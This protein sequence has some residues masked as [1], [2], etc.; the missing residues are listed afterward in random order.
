MIATAI[1]VTGENEKRAAVRQAGS[2]NGKFFERSIV[3]AEASEEIIGPR[4]MGF[5]RIGTEPQRIVH[6]IFGQRDPLWSWI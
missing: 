3:I 1:D 5:C 4:E 2:R 6:R